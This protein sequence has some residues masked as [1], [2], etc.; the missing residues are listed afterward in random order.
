MDRAYA[1]VI[2]VAAI[3]GTLA[4]WLPVAAAFIAAVFYII[5]IWES[6]TVQHWFGRTSLV[7]DQASKLMQEAEQAAVVL[8]VKAVLAAQK[9]ISD[10]KASD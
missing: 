10:N 8:Q 4:G 6:A 9:L 5:E 7:E 3:L 1:Q 2:S